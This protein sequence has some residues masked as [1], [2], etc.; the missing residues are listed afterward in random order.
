[1]LMQQSRQL[2]I[3]F[4]ML[5][6]RIGHKIIVFKGVQQLNSMVYLA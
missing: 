2:L 4:F 5:S 1:M 3:A 6:Q